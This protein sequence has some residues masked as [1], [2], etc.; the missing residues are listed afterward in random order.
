MRSIKFRV[1]DQVGNEMIEPND[2]YQNADILPNGDKTGCHLSD[3]FQVHSDGSVGKDH[4]H[5][6][7]LQYT[8]LEDKNGKEIYEGDIVFFED[9]FSSVRYKAQV[10]FNRGRFCLNTGTIPNDLMPELCE[11]IGN[12]YEHPHLLPDLVE[13]KKES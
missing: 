9:K 10:I 6:I 13:N 5:I 4:E 1:W 8:G 7:F 11:V 12:V 2:F 3:F